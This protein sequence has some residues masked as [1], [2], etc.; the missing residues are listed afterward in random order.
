MDVACFEGLAGRLRGLVIMLQHGLGAEQ[1]RLFQHF[2]VALGFCPQAAK[3]CPLLPKW[4]LS[5][6][7][8]PFT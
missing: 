3:L 1:P 2:I 5:A 8:A 6:P 7:A 4:V